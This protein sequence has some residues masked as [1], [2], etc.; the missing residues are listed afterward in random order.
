MNMLSTWINI[1]MQS[2][3]SIWFIMNPCQDNSAL[4]YVFIAIN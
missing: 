2:Q 4:C 1:S 3:D